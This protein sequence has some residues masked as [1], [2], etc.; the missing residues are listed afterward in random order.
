MS[1]Q[2]RDITDSQK[3]EIIGVNLDNTTKVINFPKDKYDWL[4]FNNDGSVGLV[5]DKNNK[6][7]LTQALGGSG[8]V[9]KNLDRDGEKLATLLKKGSTSLTGDLLYFSKKG[10]DELDNLFGEV[11]STVEFSLIKIL[12]DNKP[13]SY[14]L[15]KLVEQNCKNQQ[16]NLDEIYRL[17]LSKF[18]NDNRDIYKYLVLDS[19]CNI[20]NI[21]NY[22]EFLKLYSQLLEQKIKEKNSNNDYIIK[23]NNVRDYIRNLNLALKN[24][25]FD[26]N[27]PILFNGDKKKFNNQRKTILESK[28]KKAIET[29]IEALDKRSDLRNAEGKTQSNIIQGIYN[30]F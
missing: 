30:K 25:I 7:S 11:K 28:T 18:M 9:V 13:H 26:M 21:N 20:R 1:I 8:G 3:N 5:L 19:D 14:L 17:F 29:L 27:T 12:V 2:V 10:E 23:V 15:Q 6:N 16:K 22:N 4:L 24:K